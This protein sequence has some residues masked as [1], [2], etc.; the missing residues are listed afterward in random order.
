M[1]TAPSRRARDMV[2]SPSS[3][4]RSMATLAAPVASLRKRTGGLRLCIFLAVPSIWSLLRVV[5]SSWSISVIDIDAPKGPRKPFQPLCEECLEI[6]QR[7]SPV[8]LAYV[9]I[10]DSL[11]GRHPLMGARDEHGHFG[12]VH[13]ETALRTNPP[14]VQFP[15]EYLR[16]LC[17]RNDSTYKML[18]EKVFVDLQAHQQA[19]VVGLKRQK[20]LCVVYTTESGHAS[21]RRIR[22]TWG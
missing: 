22:E 7:A 14:S 18:S 19:H 20:I 16:T 11:R 4:L 9:K 8:D 12:Y 13:D 6:V 3:T 15:A 10:S 5:N 1:T 17:G 21:I 2:E